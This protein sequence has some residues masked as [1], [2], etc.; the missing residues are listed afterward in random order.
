MIETKRLFI[1]RFREGDWKDL[2]E[3]LSDEDIVKYEPYEIFTEDEC[4][5]EAKIRSKSNVYWAVCLKDTG[6]LIGNISLSRREFEDFS[7][8]YVFNKRFHKNGYAEEAARAI[9]N[10]AFN[11]YKAHRICAMCNP[12]NTASF[13]LLERLGFRREG[14]LRENIYFKTDAEEN[15][16]W[17]D[18]YEYGILFYEWN[19]I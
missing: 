15:P 8:G 18:T 5:I 1:R 10:L 16:I 13:H 19:K 14:H 7:L 9:I 6:K 3:Y 12:N 4:K 11:D 17:W 2:Y